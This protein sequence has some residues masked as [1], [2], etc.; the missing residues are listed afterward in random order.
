M[1]RI[2]NKLVILLVLL[3]LCAGQSESSWLIK[4]KKVVPVQS[5]KGKFEKI[6]RISDT[7]DTSVYN[8]L[9]L[10][11][12]RVLLTYTDG[13]LHIYN[14]VTNKIESMTQPK[15]WC[16]CS[17]PILLKDGRVL[18]FNTWTQCS[19]AVYTEEMLQ[20]QI[21]PENKYSQIYDPKTDTYTKAANL[22]DR[23][24]L[25]ESLLLDDGRIFMLYSKDNES[26]WKYSYEYS[27]ETYAEIY[28]P[29]LDKFYPAGESSINK[30]GIK[31]T[32]DGKDEYIDEQIKWVYS[33]QKRA[34]DE[35]E[36]EIR[37][38]STMYPPGDMR[39]RLNKKRLEELSKPLPKPKITKTKIRVQ[40]YDK[41]AVKLKDG[42]LLIKWTDSI[43]EVYDP[44]I[45]KFIRVKWDSENS[46]NEEI[47]LSNGKFLQISNKDKRA[48][49]YD[50]DSG[51]ARELDVKAISK[52]LYE[53]SKVHE[54]SNG[55][56][57]IVTEDNNDVLLFDV[58]AEEFK[59]LGRMKIPDRHIFRD[60]VLANDNELL[61]ETGY[62]RG[63]DYDPNLRGLDVYDL[64]KRKLRHIGSTPRFN[65]VY[66]HRPCVMKN[67]NILY[68]STICKITGI[69]EWA[70]QFECHED[71]YLY[72]IKKK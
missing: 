44:K 23:G 66:E 22:P 3:L 48:W 65:M 57:V 11:D 62:R 56:I 40:P 43:R 34:E 35:R 49:L 68:K 42:R 15:H 32:V 1:K 69:K 4:P 41:D 50:M 53:I 12:G 17:H 30:E 2:I 5:F 54:L 52:M 59:N 67:G 8:F 45:G 51:E 46:Y 64:K 70:L 36:R 58:R 38:L 39:E 9:N 71:L 25:F 55:N 7:D 37:R 28:D 16:A 72:K 60:A 63:Y 33:K 19:D 29:K 20:E 13:T 31:Y 18:F 27:D 10:D 61:L 6:T 24:L 26:N 14:P 47:M 21:K